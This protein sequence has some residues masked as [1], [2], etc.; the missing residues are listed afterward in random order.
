M[1]GA[2]VSLNPSHTGL[3]A[4]LPELSY[5][6]YSQ[7]PE[8][9]IKSRSQTQTHQAQMDNPQRTPAWAYTATERKCP[10]GVAPVSRPWWSRSFPLLFY[11]KNFY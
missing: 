4:C 10:V 2:A 3:P 5:C 7:N 9:M 1:Y 6:L 8:D 11:P